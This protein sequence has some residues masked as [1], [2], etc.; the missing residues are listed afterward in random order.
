MLKKI[1]RT[2]TVVVLLLVLLACAAYYYF[3]YAP[4]APEPVLSGL[5]YEYDIDIDGLERRFRAYVPADIKVGAPL[6]FVLH[7]SLR[8]GTSM[9][10]TSA[11]RFDELADERGF[12][13]I[14]PDEVDRHWNDCRASADYAANTRDIDDPAFFAK[15]VEFAGINWEV[16]QDAVFVTGISNGAHMAY[17][18]AMEQ[19]ADYR[20]IAAVAANLPVESNRDCENLNQP[21]SVAI[22]N[23]TK[24]PVNPYAG[25]LVSLFG[26]ASRGA[27]L[28]TDE[29]MQYWLALAGVQTDTATV[30]E[31]PERDQNQ[32]TSVVEQAWSSAA[33]GRQFRLYRLEGAGHVLPLFE[34][35]LPRILGPSAGDISGPDEIIEFFFSTLPT[36]AP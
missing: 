20:A 8:S 12:V 31:H 9:R 15:M 5:L 26:N 7:G 30:F 19:P 35:R 24:D 29:T 14:Y 32:A 33:S 16:N 34:Q 22:F 21:V 27:V 18:L 3:I 2:F 13:V 6:V 28:S 17:H 11:Y 25:V 4:K 36:P 23:G 10:A 1:L